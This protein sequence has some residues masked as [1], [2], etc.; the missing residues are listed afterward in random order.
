MAPPTARVWSDDRDDRLHTY[1]RDSYDGDWRRDHYDRYQDSHLARDF[2]GQWVLLSHDF[3]TRA[4][5]QI[6]DGGGERFRRLRIEAAHGEPTITKV[7]VEFANGTSQVFDLDMHLTHGAGEV[8]SFGG[9][10][11][12]IRRI[13]VYADPQSRGAYSVLG[14]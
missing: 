9:G 5:R 13:I 10:D 4:E 7:V 2:R 6:I 12:R 11:R 3:P 1:A 8:I 14:A